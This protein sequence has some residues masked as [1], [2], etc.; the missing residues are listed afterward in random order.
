LTDVTISNPTNNQIL[1]Y[2][3]SGWVNGAAP[4]T[5]SGSYNDLTDKPTIPSLTQVEADI[6]DHETRLVD[7][8]STAFVTR[9]VPSG[10]VNGSNAVFTLANTPVAGTE[11]VFLNGLLQQ[12]GAGNDYTIS[13]DTITFVTAPET[14]WKLFVN[15]ATGDYAVAPGGSASASGGGVEIFQSSEFT[16]ANGS[17]QT[18]TMTHNK[19]KLPDEIKVFV[20][21]A[22]APTGWKLHPDFWQNGYAFGGWRNTGSSANAT[23]LTFDYH[24][25]GISDG[26]PLKVRVRLYFYSLADVANAS[27]GWVTE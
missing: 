6:A 7:I 14:G 17:G 11:Q 24:P 22:D 15:Y 18:L 2:N 5:F 20:D 9:E 10:S 19:G 8:E 1:K 23:T 3:G 21:D 27:A 16:W 4:A 26:T 25:A 12:E 13:G